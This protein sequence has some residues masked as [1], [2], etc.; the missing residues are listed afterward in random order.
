MPSPSLPL[1]CRSTPKV[2][3]SFYVQEMLSPHSRPVPST[4]FP[5]SVWGDKSTLWRRGEDAIDDFLC[6]TFWVHTLIDTTSRGGLLQALIGSGFDLMTS[7]G[8]V[9]V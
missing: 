4:P 3:N 5:S 9:Q 8:N 7:R 2:G 1:K 6:K